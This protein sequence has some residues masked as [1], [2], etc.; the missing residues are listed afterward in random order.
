MAGTRRVKRP[1]I[2]KAPHTISTPPTNAP[3]TSGDGMPI[4]ANRPAPSSPGYRNFST[5]APTQRV[6]SVESSPQRALQGALTK[7]AGPGLYYMRD[8]LRQGAAT[9]TTPSYAFLKGGPFLLASPGAA[10]LSRRQDR[11]NCLAETVVYNH[12]RHG[13]FALGGHTTTSG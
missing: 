11:T 4:F 7:L 1:I 9:R 5:A 13:K 8:R 6:M 10:T 2:T 3:I 12:K